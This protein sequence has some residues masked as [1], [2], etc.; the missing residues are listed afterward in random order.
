MSKLFELDFSGSNLM[1]EHDG[2]VYEVTDTNG[3][4]VDLVTGPALPMTFT[5]AISTAA[6]VSVGNDVHTVALNTQYVRGSAGPSGDGYPMSGDYKVGTATLPS[7]FGE[8]T[9]F[10]T[11]ISGYYEGAGFGLKLI[12]YNTSRA[13]RAEI[14][15]APKDA[16]GNIILSGVTQYGMNADNLVYN[17]VSPAAVTTLHSGT[18]EKNDVIDFYLSFPPGQQFRVDTGPMAAFSISASIDYNPANPTEF[19]PG[20]YQFGSLVQSGEKVNSDYGFLDL[21][22]F[23]DVNRAFTIEFSL[24]DKA[25]D[26][27]NPNPYNYIAIGRKTYA[28]TFDVITVGVDRNKN[29]VLGV[30]SHGGSEK[31]VPLTTLSAPFEDVK[32]QLNYDPNQS[33]GRRVT[34][35]A[36]DALIGQLGTKFNEVMININ[37]AVVFFGTS[38]TT[39]EIGHQDKFDLAEGIEIKDF[40]MYSGISMDP[41]TT[42]FRHKEFEVPTIST[43]NDVVS[44]DAS[45]RVKITFDTDNDIIDTADVEVKITNATDGN[46]DIIGVLETYDSENLTMIYGFS[47]IDKITANEGFIEYQVDYYGKTYPFTSAYMQSQAL[48]TLYLDGIKDSATYEFTDIGKDYVDFKIKTVTDGGSFLTNVGQLDYQDYKFKLCAYTEQNGDP[49]GSNVSEKEITDF[50]LDTTYK[51][52]SLDDGIYYNM[53]ATLTDPAGNVKEDLLPN[54]PN[55]TLAKHYTKTKIRTVDVT[56]PPVF[57]ISKVLNDGLNFL[58]KIDGV[59]DNNQVVDAQNPLKLY[60]IATIQK[61]DN[62]ND[63]KTRLLADGDTVTWT[64]ISN[65]SAQGWKFGPKQ[66][67][68]QNS[69]ASKTDQLTTEGPILADRKYYVYAMLEDADGNQT[70]GQDASANEYLEFSEV[71]DIQFNS[72]VNSVPRGGLDDIAEETDTLKVTFTS[73]YPITDP[74]STLSASILGYNVSAP[75]AGLTADDAAKTSWTLLYPLS[76]DSLNANREELISAT[77]NYVGLLETKTFTENTHVMLRGTGVQRDLSTLATA[78]VPAF[79]VINPNDMTSANHKSLMTLKAS[80]KIIDFS[81]LKSYAVKLYKTS[82][83]SLVDTKEYDSFE[84]IAETITFN[85]LT[86]ADTYYTN[87][88]VKNNLDQE[89]TVSL[90]NDI[91]LTSI[92]PIQA[93][94]SVESI[95]Y[96][97]APTLELKGLV[98][99]DVNSAYDIFFVAVQTNLPTLD[100]AN[101]SDV[102]AV[103]AWFSSVSGALRYENVAMNQST[104]VVADK[105]NILNADNMLVASNKAIMGKAYDWTTKEISAFKDNVDELQFIGMIRDRSADNNAIIFTHKS[106][107]SYKIENIQI[108]NDK[109]PTSRFV[110]TNDTTTLTFTTASKMTAA[111]MQTEFYGTAFTPTTADGLSWEFPLQIPGSAADASFLSSNLTMKSLFGTDKDL[112]VSTSALQVDKVAPTW[113][114]VSVTSTSDSNLRINLLVSDELSREEELLVY[115]QASNDGTTATSEDTPFVE[116]ESFAD[117][118]DTSNNIFTLDGLSPGLDY[119]VKAT[120]YDKNSNATA[121][122]TF[123]PDDVVKGTVFLNDSILPLILEEDIVDDTINFPSSAEGAGIMLEKIH[124]GDSNSIYDYYV[125]ATR[126]EKT[127]TFDQLVQLKS[128]GKEVIGDSNIARGV[129]S[130]ITNVSISNYVA[131]DL[132]ERPI[133]KGAN[134][135]VHLMIRDAQNNEQS[136]TY[137]VSTSYPDMPAVVDDSGTGGDLR[138]YMNYETKSTLNNM[139]GYAHG[140]IEGK[141]SAS[142]ETGFVGSTA[143]HLNSDTFDD[144]S[145]EVDATGLTDSTDFSLY[146]WIKPNEDVS[147]LANYKKLFYYDDDHFLDVKFGSLKGKWGADFEHSVSMVYNSN[148][149]NHVAFTASA[150]SGSESWELYWNGSNVDLP[151][152][153]APATVSGLSAPYEPNFYIGGNKAKENNFRG[154]MDDT[155]VYGSFGVFEDIK[156]LNGDSGEA[157]DVSFTASNITTLD[158]SSGDG[159]LTAEEISE[160]ID[161]E[162]TA[163]GEASVI[164][165][166]STTLELSDTQVDTMDATAD[167]KLTESTVSFWI[168]PTSDTF[169]QS[170]TIMEYESDVGYK[171]SISPSGEVV[172]ETTGNTGGGGGGGSSVPYEV[173]AGAA[174]GNGTFIVRKSAITG[175]TAGGTGETVLHEFTSPADL[176]DQPAAASGNYSTNNQGRSFTGMRLKLQGTLTGV[177]NNNLQIQVGIYWP[178]SN[179]YIIFR[180]EPSKMTG[181]PNLD[182]NKDAAGFVN[183]GGGSYTY[184]VDLLYDDE[185]TGDNGW[186]GRVQRARG[187]YQGIDGSPAIFDLTSGGKPF[188]AKVCMYDDANAVFNIDSLELSVDYGTGGVV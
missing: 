52:D 148:V 77:I 34:L 12:A 127:L 41:L 114:F 35:Y 28:R 20:T 118:S 22:T 139:T 121:L 159:D 187:Q 10:K 14:S 93:S 53:K 89:Y 185:L 68:V 88:V 151:A 90:E 19:G 6:S 81:G 65:I 67:A 135:K 84:N 103:S 38:G 47:N 59:S 138:Y 134:Y 99:N 106:E 61:Y 107:F 79:S 152:P 116:F 140:I 130:Q 156:A 97:S 169:N 62:A 168:K 9:E 56:P 158:F 7:D 176:Y 8:L 181:T 117:Y 33:V 164:F 115:I 143:I 57:T 113:D 16:M 40:K 25:V 2:V 87:V 21:N 154:L 104:D 124:V 136:K 163:T 44:K 101:A 131:D 122:Q 162:D 5:G 49:Y 72:M 43:R 150:E 108:S 144:H 129:V 76:T 167:G 182:L 13:G 1:G 92:D 74:E 11:T 46:F 51:L 141:G 29:V 64:D 96:E 82:D 153:T 75:V 183:I 80:D 71:N 178:S 83:D 149:W 184:D 160:I 146:T 95:D 170:N 66:T 165:D 119:F 69:S 188:V 110:T 179:G 173:I 39:N 26:P 30:L 55:Q 174:S 126:S 123:V 63:I 111:G 180:I 78:L 171:V 37:D 27:A 70:V 109:N 32:F 45:E 73:T 137:D 142:Y 60:T 50:S 100:P 166:G 145:I 186:R 85:G 147:E 161:T 120:V 18:F 177:S 86:E 17:S 91:K 58:F 36:N 98:A 4:N 157:F 102:A 155:R 48:P 175:I 23:H 3:S 94:F 132:T 54:A 128:E 31:T 42:Y 112:K 105:V 24:T 133:Q 15:L 125:A 172:F